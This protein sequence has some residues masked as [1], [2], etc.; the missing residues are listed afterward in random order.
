VPAAEE[1]A[2]LSQ[3]LGTVGI[4]LLALLAGIV[5]YFLSSFLNLKI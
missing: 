5:A 4:I 1:P 2:S 3:R